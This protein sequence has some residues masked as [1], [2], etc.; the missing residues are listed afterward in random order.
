MTGACIINGIDIATTFG[1][2]ILRG[3]DHGF[4]SFPSRKAP[5]VIDW[6]DADG[7]EIGTDDPV[8][9]EKKVT[10]NYY[11]KGNETNFLGRLNTFISMH[12][13]SGYRAIE[14][15]EFDTTF[16]L[17]YAGVSSFSMNRG[18]SVTG[19]KAAR[20]SIDYVMDD[21]LQ[22]IGS[23]SSPTANRTIPTQ[24][25]IGGVDLSAFGIIVQDIYSSAFRYGIKDRL[26]Y[27]SAYSTGN[28][29]DT[30]YAPKRGKQELTIRCTMICDDRA[31][32]LENYSALFHALDVAS[33]TL[34][35]VAAGKQFKCY[36]SAME[37]FK[38]RPWTGRAV[39][40][41]DLKFIGYRI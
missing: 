3:G 29:A 15:R 40:G 35:M 18:F 20:I 7:F 1:V 22:F 21:P 14:V 33:F 13:A 25:Q 39:A 11:L 26:V 19:E 6:P 31:A 17:R 37:G 5:V 27:Q 16:H 24:V 9:N 32:F 30:S 12:E 38:K 23:T 10:V 34:N 28:I 8:Y 41:F 4:I 36:Y 2:T